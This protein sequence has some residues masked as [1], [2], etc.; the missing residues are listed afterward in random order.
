[1]ANR[2]IG[3]V[4]MERKLLLDSKIK[5]I[6]LLTLDLRNPH[7]RDLC[8]SGLNCNEEKETWSLKGYFLHA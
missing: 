4:K 5:T 8:N 7:I 3:R 6:D 2:G 1:M